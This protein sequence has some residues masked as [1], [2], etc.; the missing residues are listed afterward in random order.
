MIC[1]SGITER[2]K[3]LNLE[4]SVNTTRERK[5]PG[6]LESREEEQMQ[7]VQVLWGKCIGMQLSPF[8][9]LASQSP[10]FPPLLLF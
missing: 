9:A 1:S 10:P 2:R 6:R 8:R 4:N 5:K 7:S 3:R